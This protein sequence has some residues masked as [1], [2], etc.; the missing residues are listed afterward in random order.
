MI[1]L[2]QEQLQ[3]I[4]THAESSYPEECC[5]VILGNLC[6]PS[7]K[8]VE[9]IPTENVWNSATSADFVNN[10]ITYSR[11]RRYTIA[12]REMLHLQKSAR[13]R[14]LNIIGIFHSHPDY[15]AIPSEF[16][17]N[18]AWQEYSYLIVSVQKG[19]A[20]DINSWLLDDNNQ[21][22]QEELRVES[23]ETKGQEENN[24]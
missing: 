5:G 20:G 7:K 11:Q 16:D 6:D 23:W 14:N 12:P 19:Q 18:C 13:E 8:V 15:P 21:F 4:F 2:N 9:I 10:N 17:R 24:P 22:Q 3:T 1:Q